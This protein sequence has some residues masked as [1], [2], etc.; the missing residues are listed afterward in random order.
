VV[1]SSYTFS[2]T[3]LNVS[4]DGDYGSSTYGFEAS[5]ITV[6]TPVAGINAFFLQLGDSVAG[7]PITITLSDGEVIS[8]VNSSPLDSPTYFA[9]AISHDITSFSITTGAGSVFLDEMYYGA[10]SLAQDG[11]GGNGGGGDDGTTSPTSEAATFLMIG[12]GLLALLGSRRKWV[13]RYAA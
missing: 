9:I 10:S 1:L 12:G 7:A 3:N 6:T 13:A 4:I 11:N 5:S 2:G 8:T